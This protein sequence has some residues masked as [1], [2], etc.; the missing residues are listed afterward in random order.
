M[1]PTTCSGLSAASAARSFAPADRGAG[2]EAVMGTSVRPLADLY[3]SAPRD[4]AVDVG[5][6]RTRKFGQRYRAADDAL[7][8]PRLE[9]ARDALPH[10]Q[11]LTARCGRGVDA[12]QVHAAQD[13]RHDRG[14][15]LRAAGQ[16]DARDVSPEIHVPR[17][18]REQLAAH[19][20]DGAGE[21]CRFQRLAAERQLLAREH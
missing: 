5:L 19:A 11:P 20:V 18:S 16:P 14:P 1:A 9:V 3:D 4:L 7:Q 21:T 15:E 12:E 13:E 6:E 10:L 8:V 2:V 17:E